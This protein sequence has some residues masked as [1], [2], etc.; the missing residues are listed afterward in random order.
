MALH[1][2]NVMVISVLVRGRLL[3]KNGGYCM[4]KLILRLGSRRCWL[5]VDN[6]GIGYFEVRLL[7][8]IYR[9]P[10]K[11]AILAPNCRKCV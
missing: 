8:V 11:D 2:G 4:R 9:G 10:I 1:F 7:S 3:P 5:S 6:S